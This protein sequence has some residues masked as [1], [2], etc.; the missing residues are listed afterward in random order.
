MI[1]AVEAD[2]RIEFA[3]GVVAGQPSA[4]IPAVVLDHVHRLRRSAGVAGATHP[5]VNLEDT[6]EHLGRYPRL[7]LLIFANPTVAHP[8]AWKAQVIG[9]LP[10]SVV[11]TAPGLSREIESSV[12]SNAVITAPIKR[13]EFAGEKPAWSCRKRRRLRFRQDHATNVIASQAHRSYSR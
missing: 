3:K 1:G 10:R 4:N 5:A 8:P 9:R 7:V 12:D 11:G 13:T 2:A 6:V